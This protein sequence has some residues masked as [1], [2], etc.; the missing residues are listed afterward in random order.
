MIAVALLA[1]DASAGESW[2]LFGSVLGYRN[3]CDPSYIW[4]AEPVFHNAGAVD[5]NISI[6]HQSGT[7]SLPSTLTI[8]AGTSLPLSLMVGGPPLG[9][10][11]VELDAPADVVVQPRLEYENVLPC[12]GAAPALGPSGNITLP[13]FHLVDAGQAQVHYGLDLGIQSVRIN[14]GVYNAGTHLATATIALRRPSCD[15]AT[16]TSVSVP[17]DALVQVP[18]SVPP[19]CSSPVNPTPTWI[20]NAT[21]VVDQPS[22]SYATTVSNGQAPNVTF[23]VGT[24]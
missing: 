3:G 9:I 16:T 22:F 11:A 2:V 18:V 17:P 1:V 10:G 19:I 6:L 4:K 7:T 14:V 13:L 15:S 23:G 8:P 12:S 21:V 5:R 24:P 20:L